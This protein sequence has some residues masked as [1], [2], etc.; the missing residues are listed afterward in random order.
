MSLFKLYKLEFNSPDIHAVLV[1]AAG[2]DPDDIYLK[3]F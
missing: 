3:Q 1:D 2:R